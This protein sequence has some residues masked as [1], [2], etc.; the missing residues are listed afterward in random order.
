MIPHGGFFL[1]VVLYIIARVAQLFL[2]FTET[3]LF[4]RAILSWFITNEE[5]RLMIFLYAVTEPFVLPFR[6]ICRVLK[7]PE[8]VPLDIPFMLALLFITILNGVLPA[9]TL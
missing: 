1:Q 6:V 8:D 4:L 7:V 3:A 5:N 2:I 9:V